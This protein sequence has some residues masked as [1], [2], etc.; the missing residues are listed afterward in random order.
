MNIIIAKQSLDKV[1][2]KAR[3]HFYKP[4]QVAEILY[5]DRIYKDVKLSELATY[6]DRKSVV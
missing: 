5:R 1:I 6:R 4:I 3:V 2:K